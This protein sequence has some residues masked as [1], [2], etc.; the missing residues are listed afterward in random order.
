MSLGEKACNQERLYKEACV[1]L[2]PSL[3]K[4]RALLHSYSKEHVL[5]NKAV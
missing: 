2:A 4:V 5:N 3:G 1:L